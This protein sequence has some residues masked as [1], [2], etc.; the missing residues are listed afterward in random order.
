MILA[1]HLYERALKPGLINP[2]TYHDLA[3]R[4]CCK[5]CKG[6]QNDS[7]G[8]LKQISMSRFVYSGKVY[9]NSV[10]AADS[11]IQSLVLITRLS[12]CF[13]QLMYNTIGHCNL[14]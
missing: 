14:Q 3:N 4:E 2:F 12:S 9:S 1:K 8:N 10:I 11:L 5:V 13:M 6:R 7:A